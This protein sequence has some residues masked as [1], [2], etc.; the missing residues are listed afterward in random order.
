MDDGGDMDS[1]VEFCFNYFEFEF[2]H[3]LW[4]IVVIENMGIGQPSSGFCDG[5]GI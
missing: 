1:V 3:I 4:K 5:V 2:S